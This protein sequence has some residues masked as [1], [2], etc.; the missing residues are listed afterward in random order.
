MASFFDGKW[1]AD[2]LSP[3]Q[4]EGVYGYNSSTYTLYFAAC[5]GLA[6]DDPAQA[7]PRALGYNTSSDRVR[8][9]DIGS[10]MEMSDLR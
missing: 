3:D 7:N 6:V 5:H 8:Q 9:I 4:P 1:T 10:P 2:T